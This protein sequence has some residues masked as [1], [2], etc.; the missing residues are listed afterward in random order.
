MPPVLDVFEP[1][2]YSMGELRFM[3]DQLGKPPRAALHKGVPPGVNPVAIMECMGRF[4][5]Y[6][7]MER[8][9]EVPWAG[10]DAIRDSISRYIDWT[11]RT[12]EIHRR[13]GPRHASMFAWDDGRPAKFGIGA[14]SSEMV[15]SEI[16]PDGTHRPF[17]VNLRQ[18]FGETAL[19]IAEVAPWLRQGP[20]AEK[21]VDTI[22]RIKESDAVSR[23]KCS[24]CGKSFEFDANSSKALTMARASMARHLR[25]A[26]TKV[27]RHQTLLRREFTNR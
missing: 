2:K 26:T 22:E 10:E 6:A 15:R 11:E 14:D 18:P 16:L 7:E 17:A 4:Y 20:R 12:A 9:E 13:G 21:I 25:S 24:V 1:A 23:L 3:L 27:D 5:D 8:H 19:S